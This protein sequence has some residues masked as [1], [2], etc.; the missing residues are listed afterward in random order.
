MVQEFE[1]VKVVI[2]HNRGL[3]LFARHLGPNNDFTVSDGSMLRDLRI[4]NYN[5]IQPIHDENG[6]PQ[7]DIFVFRPFDLERL[8]D[9]S[10]KVGDRVTLTTLD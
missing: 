6:N 3:V 4:Y 8:F 10:F 5:D 1:I 2:H 9:K 7:T